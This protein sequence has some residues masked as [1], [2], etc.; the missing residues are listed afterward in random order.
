MIE[1]F[2]VDRYLDNEAMDHIYHALGRPFDPK[3]M[4]KRNYFATDGAEFEGDPNWHLSATWPTGMR[5]YEVTDKGRQA[6]ADYLLAHPSRDHRA[7]VVTVEFGGVVDEKAVIAR[8]RSKA[9]YS[10]YLDLA[11]AFPDLTFAGFCRHSTCRVMEP[12]HG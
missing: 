4:T 2:R 6:L 1:N 7:Y 10:R 9:R 3:G 11:D 12:P 8:T 5:I